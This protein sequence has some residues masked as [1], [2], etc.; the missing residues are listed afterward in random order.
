MNVSRHPRIAPTKWLVALAAITFGGIAHAA[1]PPG[2]TVLSGRPSATIE[3]AITVDD[4]PSHGE[5]IPGL[6][7][8]QIHQQMLDG[9]V[10]HRVPQVYGFLCAEALVGHDEDLAGVKAWLDAGYPVGNHT[11]SH[12]SLSEIGV[13]RYLEDV[14]R[15]EE[16]LRRLTGRPEYSWKV[17]RYP[18]QFEG[19]DD[20][21]RARIRQ[22]LASR[23][24]RI[25]PVT[26]DF[27]DWKFNDAYIAALARNDVTAIAEL[28]ERYLV[29]AIEALRSSDRA[30]Q[31]L[32]GRRI[33]HVLLLHVGAF[34]AAMMES[35]LQ[36]FEREGVRFITLDDALRDP[37]YRTS[38]SRDRA[39]SGTFLEQVR[40]G[41][42]RG[43]DKPP[44]A[45]SSRG[46]ATP[47]SRT[48]ATRTRG[49]E[50]L[51]RGGITP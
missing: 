28:R 27:T 6:T 23:E 16:P 46:R 19:F 48:A 44:S 36:A 8:L 45:F 21:S 1:T 17:F 35:M 25:A 3:V 22:H 43:Q 50:R 47:E 29:A 7:R 4:I 32:F 39:T 33:K 10:A 15:N 42:A 49:G 40:N 38:W 30:S 24:Y 37:V 12:P 14:D 51:L 11:Y 31:E 20:D 18:F 2:T 9:L 13:D 34:P 26:I 5:P 41:K